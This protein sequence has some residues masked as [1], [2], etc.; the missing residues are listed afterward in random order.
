MPP[1]SFRLLL[2]TDRQQTSGR[3]LLAVLRQAIHA[4]VPAIQLRERDL[5]VRELMALATDIQTAAAPHAV[6]LMVN[7]R[8]DVALALALAGVH[9]RAN[10]LP[11]DVARRLLG[12]NSLIGI[13]T[14]S[15]D[16][17]R[18]A[19]EQGADYVV[20]G[21]VFDTPSKRSY[22]SP[23]GLDGLADACRH[24]SVPVFAIG[25]V[26]SGRVHDVRRAGAHGVAVIGAILRQV[27]VVA[28][29]RELVE[30]LRGS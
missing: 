3:P 4:G 18:R 20:F 22:G 5:P 25:G 16:E 12:R 2:V 19:S 27:D 21:P 14:H 11:V 8:V 9:L 30:A 13:S 26:T 24:A 28:A 7:D 6:P 29:T 1:V 10:S 23:F 17:V 15:I